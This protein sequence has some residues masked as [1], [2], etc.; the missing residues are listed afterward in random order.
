VYGVSS[1]VA[2]VHGLLQACAAATFQAMG[3][4]EADAGAQA[5]SM[6]A[7]VNEE[8]SLRLEVTGCSAPPPAP[9]EASASER[10]A[11]AVLMAFAALLA[12]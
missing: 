5:S 7:Y 8:R 10:V 1:N 6:A 9:T 12:S 4:P 11:P 2:T 3:V